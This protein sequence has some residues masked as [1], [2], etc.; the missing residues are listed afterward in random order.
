M[1]ENSTKPELKVHRIYTKA[2]LFEAPTLNLKLLEMPPK[3]VLDLK[4]S[5]NANSQDK[6]KGLHEAILTIELMAKYQD[7][8]LWRIQY[9]HAGLYTL[10]GFTEAVAKRILQG[11]CMNQMYPYACAEVNRLVTQGGFLPVYLSPINFE[12]ES[13]K[14]EQADREKKTTD[15]ILFD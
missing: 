13:Q 11:F 2:S 3:P 8:V 7:K 4:I 14:A 12:V 9:Q 15:A 10:I 1:S 6:D 5:A